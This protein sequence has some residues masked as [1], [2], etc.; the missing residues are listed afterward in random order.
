MQV[1]GRLKWFVRDVGSFEGLMSW[2]PWQSEHQAALLW[3]FFAREAACQ[4]LA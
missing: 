2:D 4:L 1:A 3:G